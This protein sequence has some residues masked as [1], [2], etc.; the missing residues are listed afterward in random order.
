MKPSKSLRIILFF[1]TLVSLN[2]CDQNFLRVIPA[3]F[4]KEYCSCLYVEKLD[5]K[6][7]RNYAE[8]IIK[9]DRYYHN[10][11]KKM[12]VASGLGH[13]ATAF[14]TESRLGCHLLE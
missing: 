4:V 10:P 3:S 6:T 5:D 11:Q 14:Y 7:C 1:F 2:S 9:V 8:Q 13:T 12:I